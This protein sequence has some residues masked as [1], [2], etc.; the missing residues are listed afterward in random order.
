LQR[1]VKSKY[2]NTRRT[3]GQYTF[4][5]LKEARR[6]EELLK[7]EGE[8]VISHLQCQPKYLLQEGFKKNGVTHRAIYYIADFE[9]QDSFGILRIEDVKGVETDVFKIKRKLFE[10][11]YPELSLD[12]VR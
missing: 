5:S 1:R 8:G 3:V 10:Y 6:Y 2:H 11:K 12:V 4:S 9:Y 7:L